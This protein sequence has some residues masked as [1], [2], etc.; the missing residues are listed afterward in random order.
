L[1]QT[2]EETAK[3]PR[4]HLR[5]YLTIEEVLR[6]DASRSVMRRAQVERAIRFRRLGDARVHL[7]VLLEESPTDGELRFFAGVVEEADRHYQKAVAYYHAAIAND[8]TTVEVHVRLARILRERLTRPQAADRIMDAM[9]QENKNS[10]AARLARAVYRKKYGTLKQ[11]LTDVAAAEKLD[12]KTIAALLLRAEWIL[13]D[14]N[15]SQV[16]VKEIRDRLNSRLTKHPKE[17]R[18]YR[19][20]SQAELR[21]KQTQRAIEVFR[22]GRKALPDDV[23]LI[24]LLADLLISEKKSDEA[25]VE[26]NRLREL[27]AAKWII[28]YLEGRI[29]YE[30]EKILAARTRL[31]SAATHADRSSGIWRNAHLLLGECYR[32]MGAYQRQLDTCGQV[33]D[34]DPLSVKGRLGMA[35]A[36][37]SLGRTE[38]A[39]NIYVYW[40]KPRIPG[41]ELQ[42]ARLLFTRNLQSAVGKRDWPVVERVLN[43]LAKK[44][45]HSIEVDLMRAELFVIRGQRK[46]AVDFLQ[47]LQKRHPKNV[48]VRCSL[49]QLAIHAEDWKTAES[50]L[51]RT[52]KDLGDSLTWRITRANLWRQRRGPEA[53]KALA[54]LEQGL[55]EFSTADQLRIREYLAGIWGARGDEKR[56]ARLWQQIATAHPYLVSPRFHRFLVAYGQS[57]R[58]AMQESLVALRKI[59]GSSGLH[60]QVAEAAMLIHTGKYE[61]RRKAETVLNRVRDRRPNWPLVYVLRATIH[62]ANE[63]SESAVEQYQRAIELGLRSPKVLRRTFQLLYRL[64]YYREMDQLLTVLSRDT[65]ATILS[66]IRRVSAAVSL[67]SGDFKRALI[68]ARSAVRPDSV[69]PAELV[70][71]GRIYLVSGRDKDAEREFRKAIGLA[72]AQ[73]A[74]RVVLIQLLVNKGRR[75]EAEQAVKDAVSKLQG[76]DAALQLGLCHELIGNIATAEQYYQKALSAEGSRAEVIRNVAA[77]YMR[78]RR[79]KQAEPLLRRLID[80]KPPF[81]D[82]SVH[83]ARRSLAGVIATRKYPGFL[84]AI[85]L[86]DRNLTASRNSAADLLIKAR[87][88]AVHP[89]SKHRRDAVSIFEKIASQTALS[90][91][92]QKRLVALYDVLAQTQT[93]DAYWKTLLKNNSSDPSILTAYVRRLMQHKQLI[94]AQ[95]WWQRLDKIAPRSPVTIELHA[96]LLVEKNHA[97]D[98]IKLLAAY[99]QGNVPSIVKKGPDETARIGRLSQAVLLTTNLSTTMDLKLTQRNLLRR[100]TEKWFR[101]LVPRQPQYAPVFVVFLTRLKRT[102]EAL[103]VLKSV[104]AKLP[105]LQVTAAGI[106]VVR[107]AHAGA[108]Q[109][110]RVEQ[111]LD[112]ILEESPGSPGVLFQRAE[113]RIIQQRYDDAIVLYQMV[114]RTTPNHSV[115]LNNLAW[116]LSMFKGRHDAAR[117]LIDRAVVSVGPVAAYL[118]TRGSIRLLQGDVAGAIRDFEEALLQSESSLTRFRLAQAHAAAGNL[119]AAATNLQKANQAGLSVDQL[120]TFERKAYLAL[121]QKLK[122]VPT[123]SP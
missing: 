64:G 86:L 85:A 40:S 8:H 33:V 9:V 89:G 24:W 59:E 3:T 10:A 115:S 44:A 83:W 63:S 38:E 82:T 68:L 51:A 46:Q 116:Y 120:E 109:V 95:L 16:E 32:K 122:T 18:L 102:D 12:P 53:D 96:R 97:A 78:N 1:A 107:T 22:L 75:Q 48:H 27:K 6:R 52:R 7:D 36:Y 73:P 43:G 81:P 13:S 108:A 62:D 61:N 117:E 47:Q 84:Q 15:R 20:L 58:P 70:W 39:L 21:L 60:V 56:S 90:V 17:P 19:L 5:V 37:V 112:R 111:W 49:A 69:D 30:N 67:Q 119:A 2:L 4:D 74:P 91:P 121:N 72:P 88:L 99:I 35:A 42:V 65:S 34:A 98:A 110:R 113:L 14:P 71:L 92:D 28:D 57:D 106:A 100:Q 55:D 66:P 114:L 50:I 25:T 118:E 94:Q 105:A 79:S 54:Q 103:D 87:L 104:A 76:D 45:D 26:I 123:P 11:A 93:A 101:E 80:Q 29:L 77:F 41:L 23:N 31:Q